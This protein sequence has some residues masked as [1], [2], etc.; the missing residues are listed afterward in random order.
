MNLESKTI[1][2]KVIPGIITTGKIDTS[3][4]NISG[5]QPFSGKP[6]KLVG[7]YHYLPASGDLASFEMLLSKWNT[8]TLQRDTIAYGKFFGAEFS[9]GVDFKVFEILLDYKTNLLADPDSQ[10]VIISSTMDRANP[11]SGSELWVDNLSLVEMVTGIDNSNKTAAYISYPNPAVNELTFR[12]GEKA[13]VIT[14]YDVLGN[15]VTE[16]AVE[17]KE[18]VI[19]TSTFS[20]GMYYYTV[21]SANNSL[22]HKDKF[23]IR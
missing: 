22:L 1:S 12:T 3:N 18:M 15:K 14:I 20:K 5:G 11:K 9:T 17:Q 10:L 6:E 2:G 7:Y 19:N 23:I 16:V 21:V 4:L 8:T 13:A